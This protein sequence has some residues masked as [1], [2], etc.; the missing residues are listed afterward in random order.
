MRSLL[1]NLRVPAS[2]RVFHLSSGT[3]KSYQAIVHGRGPSPASI[4]T[5]LGGDPWWEALKQ[6]RKEEERR[7]KEA[8]AA[9]AA[10]AKKRAVPSAMPFPDSSGGSNATAAGVRKQSKRE[11]K[12]LGVSLPAEHLEF[13]KRNM[14][15]GLAHPRAKKISSKARAAADRDG[16]KRRTRSTSGALEEGTAEHLRRGN[17]GSSLG[18]ETEDSDEEESDSDEES[19]LSDELASLNLDDIDWVG[20]AGS[21]TTG[22]GL[23]RTKTYGGANSTTSNSHRKIKEANQRLLPRRQRTYSVGQKGHGTPFASAA[24]PGPSSSSYGSF[25]STPRAN[26]T[27]IKEEDFSTRRPRGGRLTSSSTLSSASSSAAEEED[28]EEIDDD[29]GTLKASDRARAQ[30]ELERRERQSRDEEPTKE[31]FDT[32]SVSTHVQFNSLPNKAQYLILK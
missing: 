29:D 13:F 3:N 1:D 25:G 6:L 11:Q 19:D 21:G 15:I 26:N 20:S 23:R 18:S 17:L 28:G 10:A 12:L 5:A 4:E 22:N 8:A 16:G 30:A 9:A 7:S 32:V 2:L 14:Q 24:A 27:S 31:S